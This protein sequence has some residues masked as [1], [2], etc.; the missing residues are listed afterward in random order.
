MSQR[1]E[2]GARD[3]R[4]FFLKEC[5]FLPFLR[6][7]RE[8]HEATRRFLLLRCTVVLL[9]VLFFLVVWTG[10]I[11]SNGLRIGGTFWAGQCLKRQRLEK[12]FG[13][14]LKSVSRGH[15]RGRDGRQGALPRCR[16]G[17]SRLGGCPRRRRR[18]IGN[19]SLRIAK[20]FRC[21][22]NPLPCT[23][24]E[25][26]QPHSDSIGSLLRVAG[27]LRW[28]RSVA[29]LEKEATMIRRIVS[30]VRRNPSPTSR[31][32]GRVCNRSQMR[33]GINCSRGGAVRRC[34]FMQRH[35]NKAMLKFLQAHPSRLQRGVVAS[36]PVR[37]PVVPLLFAQFWKRAGVKF[38]RLESRDN[39]FL[40]NETFLVRAERREC[41]SA[42]MLV[43]IHVATRQKLECHQ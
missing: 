9:L 32:P 20:V 6:R 31:W 3:I 38:K 41:D 21:V 18:W 42:L 17:R 34:S 43:V 4:Y 15:S 19:S 23:A 5:F 16:Q 10:R 35:F 28:M 40:G 36:S 37:A 2:E 30:L 25:L 13:G 29:P 8:R 39:C 1:R 27:G 33:S 11:W 22:V 26:A 12:S 14:R 24:E 7:S